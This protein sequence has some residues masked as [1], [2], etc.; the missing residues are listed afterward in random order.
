MGVG[1]RTGARIDKIWPKGQD[2]M[3]KTRQSISEG[4]A[5]SNRLNFTNYQLLNLDQY[6]P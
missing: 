4:I 2:W 1:R 5:N 6:F 3:A